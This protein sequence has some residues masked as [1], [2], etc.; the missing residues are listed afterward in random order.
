TLQLHE[1]RR[2]TLAHVVGDLFPAG[3][4]LARAEFW[5]GLRPMTPDGTPII[6]AT[7][8]RGLYLA[9]GHARSAGRPDLGP[10]PANRPRRVDHRALRQP[11][12][13]DLE[14]RHSI[15]RRR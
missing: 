3:G 13:R 9:T 6:G 11:A 12:P 1:A 15:F 2:R 14:F 4:D 5:C 10:C 7:R 8:L